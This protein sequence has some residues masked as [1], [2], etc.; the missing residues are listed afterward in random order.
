[1]NF[2]QQ[3]S[4]MGKRFWTVHKSSAPADT[5]ITALWDPDQRNGLSHA[6]ILI[7]GNCKIKHTLS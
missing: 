4:D 5:L 6:G 2:P 7:H 3:P 1:M